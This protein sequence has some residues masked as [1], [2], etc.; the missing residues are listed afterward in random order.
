MEKEKYMN[1]RYLFD[2]VAAKD[3]TGM[4]RVMMH[5]AC[6]KF[7]LTMNNEILVPIGDKVIIIIND[8]ALILC[9]DLLANSPE[10]PLPYSD[11]ITGELCRLINECRSKPAFDILAHYYENGGMDGRSIDYKLILRFYGQNTSIDRSDVGRHYIDY[12]A[13]LQQ[14]NIIRDPDGLGIWGLIIRQDD[15]WSMEKF[16]DILRSEEYLN[17]Y[18]R[19]VMILKTISGVNYICS[20]PDSFGSGEICGFQY[21]V[22]AHGSHTDRAFW[23]T[24]IDYMNEKEFAEKTV[25]IVKTD[26]NVYCP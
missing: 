22:V 3:Y 9:L 21:E 6:K 1:K 5:L 4:Y 13:Q 24:L 12:D 19:S 10:R 2:L 23:L 15:Y 26:M 18:G 20:F 17:R 11:K 8:D 25:Q 14:S 16:F 7:S